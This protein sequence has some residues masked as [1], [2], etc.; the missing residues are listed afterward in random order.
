MELRESYLLRIRQ[1]LESL[2]HTLLQ[3]GNLCILLLAHSVDLCLR[4]IE[5]GEQVVDLQLLGLIAMLAR[6]T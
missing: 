1:L 3:N 5:L 2:V 6:F 4:V